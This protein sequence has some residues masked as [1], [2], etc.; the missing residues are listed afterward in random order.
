M[1]KISNKVFFK[2][3]VHILL[4]AS[5]GAFHG[6]TFEKAAEAQQ[7]NPAPV[8]VGISPGTAEVVICDCVV[9]D[10]ELGA[11]ADEIQ[12]LGRHTI[13]MQTDVTL[14]PEVNNLVRRVVDELGTVD[15]LVNEAGISGGPALIE[16]SEDEWLK[17]IDVN[18]KGAI[19]ALR[20]WVEEWPNEEV[21]TLSISLR[22]RE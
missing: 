18:L 1:K 19:Y 10:G 6:G 9:E 5:L 22:Q 12:G 15:I 16:S 21:V 20:R 2:I 8:I 13:A 7:Q 3:I 17:I 11:V 14:K 4:I